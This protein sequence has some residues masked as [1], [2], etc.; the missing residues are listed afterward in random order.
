MKTDLKCR[1][2]EIAHERQTKTDPSHDVNHVIRVL[3]LAEKIAM[4]VNFHDVI[5]YPKNSPQSKTETDESAELAG[6]LLRELDGYPI[7]KI[8]KVQMAIRQC[9]YSKGII[10]DLLEAK[11]LQDADVIAD[12]GFAGFIRPFSFGAQTGRGIIDSIKFLKQATQKVDIR[13]LNLDISRNIASNQLKI[14]KKLVESIS[15]DINIIGCGSLTPNLKNA[16]EVFRIAKSINPKIIS[17]CTMD[18]F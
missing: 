10:P 8:E 12:L 18:I 1:L 14:Q 9:S 5:V 2:L 3:N 11:V 15:K 6:S 7:E 4:S 16:V 17:I 13:L